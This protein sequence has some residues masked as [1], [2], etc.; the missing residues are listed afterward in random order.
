MLWWK[1]SAIVLIS[2]MFD[3]WV[4]MIHGFSVTVIYGG[5]SLNQITL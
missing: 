5:R 2:N 1:G 4:W 3:C